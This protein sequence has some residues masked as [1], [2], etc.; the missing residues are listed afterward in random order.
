MVL[1]RCC[2]GVAKVLLWCCCGVVKVLTLTCYLQGLVDEADKMAA[3]PEAL[4]TVSFIL[5][6]NYAKLLLFRLKK[7]FYRRFLSFFKT[8][9][10]RESRFKQ[11]FW[12]FLNTKG[13]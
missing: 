3:A 9:D 11:A 10:S 12:A 1:L 5:N 8:F 4:K 6:S 2:Y 7:G 13:S